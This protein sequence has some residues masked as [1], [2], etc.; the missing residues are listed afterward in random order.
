[1]VGLEPGKAT[2][3]RE[4]VVGSATGPGLLWRVLEAKSAT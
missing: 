1:M 3:V 2:Q 4:T